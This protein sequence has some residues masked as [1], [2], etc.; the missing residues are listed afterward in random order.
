[1]S[2][3]QALRSIA[4]GERPSGKL[5]PPGRLGAFGSTFYGEEAIVHSFRQAPVDISEHATVVERDGHLAVFD[6]ETVL[7]ADLCGGALSRLWRLGPGEPVQAEPALGVPFDPDLRQSRGDL[8]M[9]A[10]DH[11]ELSNEAIPQVEKIG[12]SLARAGSAD[13]GPTPFRSRS[14]LIRA[15]SQGSNNV[16]LFAV[17]TLGPATVRTAG[18]LYAA[19]LINMEE[20]ELATQRVVRDSAGEAALDQLAW[21]PRVE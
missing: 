9:R 6:G 11:L 2:G 4:R 14:F 13:G 20:N 3:L 5:L 18:F 19:A 16:A 1:M 12:R 21:R 15:F 10:E 7:I 8:A 17:H